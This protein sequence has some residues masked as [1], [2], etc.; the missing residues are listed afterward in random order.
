MTQQTG[1]L[2]SCAILIVVLILDHFELFRGSD[3]SEERT[4]SFATIRAANVTAG[5]TGKKIQ[6]KAVASPATWGKESKE[7]IGNES[8]QAVSLGRRGK[9]MAAAGTHSQQKSARA[10]RTPLDGER[11]GRLSSS[12]KFR[13]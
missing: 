12:T 7:S 13:E 11:G 2:T 5:R 4:K 6:L 9:R 1:A 10:G 8:R 3:K